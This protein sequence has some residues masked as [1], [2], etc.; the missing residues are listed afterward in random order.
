MS[1]K[2]RIHTPTKVSG[3][4]FHYR[5]KPAILVVTRGAKKDAVMLVTKPALDLIGNPKKILLLYA[6]DG[7]FGM[8]PVKEND[9]EYGKAFS[10]SDARGSVSVVSCRS[11]I[12]DHELPLNVANES[13][14]TEDGILVF[15]RDDFVPARLKA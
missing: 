10:V 5:N 2:W 13:I 3:R 8:R 4:Y 1:T 12:R 14:F 7:L 15:G 9:P 11:F 6:G